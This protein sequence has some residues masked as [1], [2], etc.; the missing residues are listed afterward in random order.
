MEQ[1]SV[2][3]NQEHIDNGYVT[4]HDQH[5]VALAIAD[6]LD[7]RAV[8]CGIDDVE[9]S[10]KDQKFY[11]GQLPAEVRELIEDL[12]SI[13]GLHQDYVQ[14]GTFESFDF[15]LDLVRH[16]DVKMMEFTPSGVFSVRRGERVQVRI[17]ID[18]TQV[19]ENLLMEAEDLLSKC[20]I[21]FDTGQILGGNERHWEL[22]YSLK[23]ADVLF[24][25]PSNSQR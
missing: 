18:L 14:T 11:K 17:R 2:T 24:F 22:D 3:I 9:I 12:D 7:C 13:E 25:A 16:K 21:S 10:T 4:S 15:D 23:G 1:V 6:R 20:G 8:V 19:D 5:P